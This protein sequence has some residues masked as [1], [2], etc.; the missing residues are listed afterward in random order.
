RV[1]GLDGEFLP[2]LSHRL[3]GGTTL[4]DVEDAQPALLTE[5]E[6]ADELQLG[7]LGGL[8]F[9]G[10]FLFR[11]EGR[12]HFVLREDGQ[13]QERRHEGSEG[14]GRKSAANVHGGNRD[15]LVKDASRRGQ[16]TANPQ[17]SSTSSCAVS[18]HR[19]ILPP[20]C[21]TYRFG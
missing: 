12:S 3:P 14:Q 15:R 13:R 5:A 10:L 2:L 20:S 4:R 17:R 6:D 21:T 11:H 7:V 16:V 1:V 9:R 8:G 18:C 19:R